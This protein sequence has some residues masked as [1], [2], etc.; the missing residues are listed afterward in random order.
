MAYWKLFAKTITWSEN[1]VVGTGV[2]NKS[3]GKLRTIS[4]TITEFKKMLQRT[5]TLIENVE[6]GT[7]VCYFWSLGIL[8]NI[9]NIVPWSESFV[10]ASNLDLKNSHLLALYQY[11]YSWPKRVQ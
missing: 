3:L 8:K 5:D 4:Q 9:A 11:P 2:C 6:G 1:V 7:G 10:T